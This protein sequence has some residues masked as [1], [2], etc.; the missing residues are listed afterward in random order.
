VLVSGYFDPLLA[1]HAARLAGLKR[2]GV[3][4]VVLISSYATSILPVRARAELVAG[5]RVVNY[6]VEHAEGLT[7]QVRL[8]EEDAERLQGL[9][10]LVQRRQQAASGTR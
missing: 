8:E 6:V 7:A 4:L 1:S 10:E 5:L 9:I 3:P 2:E